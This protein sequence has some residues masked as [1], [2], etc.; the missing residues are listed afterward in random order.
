MHFNYVIF[1]ILRPAKHSLA[2]ERRK[3]RLYR[4]NYVLSQRITY[5]IGFYRRH[6]CGHRLCAAR[7]TQVETKASV[8]S[9]TLDDMGHERRR[10]DRGGEI[11]E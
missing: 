10:D 1:N 3:G 9:L 7:P 8:S 2:A 6:Y 4:L 5:D 11:Y